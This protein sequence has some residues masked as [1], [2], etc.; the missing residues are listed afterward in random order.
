MGDNVIHIE[1]T[2]VE[3]QAIIG[4]PDAVWEHDVR[5]AKTYDYALEDGFMID[6]IV[7]DVT[8]WLDFEEPTDE[9]EWNRILGRSLE[10]FIRDYSDEPIV[11]LLKKWLEKIS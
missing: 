4:S 10:C 8:I 3:D 9:S 5:R 7:I 11:S 2:Y 1:A 6:D